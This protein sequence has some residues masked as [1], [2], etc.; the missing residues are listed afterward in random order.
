MWNEKGKIAMCMYPNEVGKVGIPK[1]PKEVSKK[2]VWNVLASIEYK[3][4]QECS[5]EE[6]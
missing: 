3:A 1:G 4:D 2:N 6:A 5:L